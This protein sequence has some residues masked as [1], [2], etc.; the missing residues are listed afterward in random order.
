[1][2]VKIFK[3]GIVKSQVAL[4]LSVILILI[5]FSEI[6]VSANGTERTGNELTDEQTITLSYSDFEGLHIREGESETIKGVTI[7]ARD[8]EVQYYYYGCIGFVG[9]DS[10][11]SFEFSMADGSKIYRIEIDGTIDSLYGDDYWTVTYPG[12]V[13]QNDDGA[14]SVKFGDYFDDVTSI[15]VTYR[16]NSSGSNKWI[17]FNNYGKEFWYLEEPSVIDYSANGY[18]SIVCSVGGCNEGCFYRSPD[19][20]LK[21]I[22]CEHIRTTDP[23][24][25][26]THTHN[27][28]YAKDGES[29]KAYCLETERAEDCNY[30]GT[31]TDLT[32]A[33][34]LI[35]AADS[36]YYSGSPVQATLDSTAW[37]AVELD[38]PTIAYAHKNEANEFV[39]MTVDELPTEAGVYKASITVEGQTAEIVYEIWAN[40]G[41]NPYEPASNLSVQYSRKGVNKNTVRVVYKVSKADI[42]K[43]SKIG[44][45]LEAGSGTTISSGDNL[46]GTEVFSTI[47]A[48]TQTIHAGE[49]YYFVVCEFTDV[50]DND[51]FYVTA[52]GVNGDSAVNMTSVSTEKYLVNM[53]TILN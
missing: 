2:K 46:L 41:P 14:T 47:K 37:E 18:I 31:A 39:A 8:G 49:G 16:G 13:W 28:E 27:W 25:G 53:E 30:Q 51:K 23:T 44:V 34:S 24:G 35:L 10:G 32:N 50:K 9:Y 43:C 29:I 52:L 42:D 48:G 1:M 3:K 33:V 20:W 6:N 26:S 11:D 40:E 4:M 7:H 22:T 15:T 5:C 45:K 17:H 38:V 21:E 12:A 19:G 36:T